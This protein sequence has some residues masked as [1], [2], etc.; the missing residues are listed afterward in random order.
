MRIS[1]LQKISTS[2][3]KFPFFVESIH[4]G[5]PS[6]AEDFIDKKI[7][8]DELLVKHPAATYFVR[9]TGDSMI[10]SA[11]FPNDILIVDKSLE[12]KSGDVVIAEVDGE[13]TVKIFRK[14]KD[15]I[16]LEASNSKKNSEF[17]IWNLEFNVWGV[18]VYVVHSM[19]K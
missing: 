11:I 10:D 14:T 6:P 5:F 17:G 12:P 16:Y 13:F 4:A 1:K 18:V 8:L 9:A 7:S 2:I 19:R 15:K 3:S